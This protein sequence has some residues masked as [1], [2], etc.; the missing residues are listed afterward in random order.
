[1]RFIFLFLLIFISTG[2]NANVNDSL[3]NVWNDDNNTDS[4]RFSALTQ[5]SWNTIFRDKDSSAQLIQYFIR[6]SQ[7][8]PEHLGAAYNHAGVLNAISGNLDLAN[9]NY[10]KAIEVYT[11]N[12]M[13]E[14]LHGIYNNIGM[15]FRDVGMY[16]SAVYYFNIVIEKS[17]LHHDSITESNARSNLGSILEARGNPIG[18]I[19]Q[20]QKSLDIAIALDRKE[21]IGDRYIDMAFIYIEIKDYKSAQKKIGQALEL[22][23]L[24]D[25]KLGKANCAQ[26]LGEI[27]LKRNEF[28]LALDQLLG[29]LD[30]YR[31]IKDFR[32]V[33]NTYELI[34]QTY[35]GM[36]KVYEANKYY[37]RCLDIVSDFGDVH[38]EA[39]V[40]SHI[41]LNKIKLKE[42]DKALESCLTGYDIAQKLGALTPLKENCECLQK[43]YH[44]TDQ[45]D[46]AFKYL[47]ELRVLEDSIS[48]VEKTREFTT[49][50]LQYEFDKIASRDSIEKLLKDQEILE[51]KNEIESEKARIER[52]KM[53]I[54]LLILGVISL[55]FVAYLIYFK[56]KSSEKRRRFIKE[57]KEV[58]DTKQKEIL[59]SIY[60]A[61]RIQDALL[62]QE[63]EESNSFPEHFVM[64]QPKDI[65][66]GDFYWT[67]EK[68]NHI[69]MAVADCTGHGVPGAFLTMIGTAFLN[70]ITSNEI[71]LSPA[72][73]L[74]QLRDRIIQELCQGG[75]DE[76]TKD[77]MDIS[78]VRI[79]KNSRKIEWAGANNPLYI[80]RK[81]EII[82][83][84][85][86]SQPIGFYSKPFPFTNYNFD[87][88]E[89][90]CLY[91]F[92]DGYA[93]QFGG[94]K[95]KKLKYKPFKEL[96]KNY[97][98]Q[99]MQYQKVALS[100]AFND[101]KGEYD[102]IDDVCLMGIR[103]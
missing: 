73:V 3:W 15:G 64:F 47:T 80:L 42:Y 98:N 78:L 69:Y 85:G 7:R 2:I 5:V 103:F 14:R 58:V 81:Q 96:L 50:T 84:K 55:V 46:K 1:M 72:E 56:F 74:N 33:Y 83:V 102:Q 51:Q 61:K 32:G 92:S 52:N 93:D 60:Y 94:E 67:L 12:D 54:T 90:D 30:L 86:D 75:A 88:E 43:A 38:T 62:K 45:Y 76:D 101:W 82:Q 11:E 48:S 28:T 99:S 27:H 23:Q 35:D 63:I 59:D 70:E 97:S 16:D 40:H 8:Y 100:E 21:S 9:T 79:E 6:E 57:Q 31:Q 25:N 26:L 10:K 18:A 34:G 77:G 87:L 53:W 41:G 91:M 17:M 24:T 19:A 49:K 22:F 65:V 13:P 95:G 71:P 66:S 68:Q 4:L 20:Y 39:M 89:G 44:H 37:Q 36:N 29:A